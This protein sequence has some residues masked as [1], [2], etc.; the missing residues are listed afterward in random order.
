MGW[1]ES[2]NVSATLIGFFTM[3]GAILGGGTLAQLFGRKKGEA[4]PPPEFAEVKGALI[5]DKSAERIVQSS[6]A[7]TSASMA[8]KGAID[9]DVEAK[10]ALTKALNLNV[11][12]MERNADI[13][14]DNTGAANSVAVRAHDLLDAVNDLAK[15]ME[16]SSR[17]RGRRE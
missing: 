2:P 11:A 7:F 5:S 1:L 9:R 8:L 6:D 13:L 12:A 14:K 10:Q 15:E 16:I 17:L 3:L 4:V